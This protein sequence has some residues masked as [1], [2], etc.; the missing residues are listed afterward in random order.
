MYNVFNMGIGMVLVVKERD[1][2]AVVAKVGEGEAF[3]IGKVI[4]GDGVSFK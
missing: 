3:V 1:V 2:S 4:L